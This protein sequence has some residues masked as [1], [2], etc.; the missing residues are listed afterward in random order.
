M[1]TERVTF[2][3]S[4]DVK[5]AITARATNRGLS[6]GEY[7]RQKAMD[8]DDLSPEDEAEL[9]ALVAEANAA[10]PKMQ[11]SLERMIVRL[12]ESNRKNDE[13]LRKMGVR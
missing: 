7:V 8:D 6:L 12:E 10:I 4:P 1:Q 3:A 5:R 2:L 9:A 11:A 13:F